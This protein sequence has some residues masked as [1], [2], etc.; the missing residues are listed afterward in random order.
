MLAALA[1]HDVPGVERTDLVTRTH[2]RA[3]RT[4]DGPVVVRVT[5][6]DDHV[7]V[8]TEPRVEDTEW[9]A[10]SV[11][12]WLDLDADPAAIES[13]LGDDP[14]VGPLVRARP[15]LRVLGYL[16][17]FEGAIMTVIGQQVSLA[18]TRTFGGRLVAAFGTSVDDRYRV[19]PTPWQLASATPADVQRAVGLTG[20]R[21]ATLV[22]LAEACA[23][24]L[25]L[26]PGAEGEPVRSALRAVPGIGPWTVDYLSVRALGDRDAFVPGDLVLRRALGVESIREAAALSEAWRPYR[27]YALFH[28]WTSAAYAR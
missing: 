27:A 5:F 22:R 15:G 26:A 13:T 10:A 18:A 25:T 21:A 23:A 20:A 12:R 3:T 8:A 14:I 9:L 11:R 17:T 16:D 19:Y 6:R 4:P 28:L 1:A 2:W 7:C 24:G